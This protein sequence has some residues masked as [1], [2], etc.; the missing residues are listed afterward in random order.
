MSN[1]EK[2]DKLLTE[3]EVFYLATLDGDVPKCRPIGFHM[4]KD[5]KIYFGIGTFKDV[6]KQLQANPNLEISAWNGDKILRY[7]GKAKF[8]NSEELLEETY[9]LMPEMAELYKANN[10]EMGI[11][12]IDDATAEIRNMMEVENIYKFKY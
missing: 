9:K 5:N 4:L 7:Y 1:I 10:W 12:Y 3:S 6:Y 11:F 2:I 8:D